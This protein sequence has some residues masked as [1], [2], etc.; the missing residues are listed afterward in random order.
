MF[1]RFTRQIPSLTIQPPVDTKQDPPNST[2]LRRSRCLCHTWS[3][4]AY[5]IV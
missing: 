1:C 4:Q 3:S 5:A 2:S